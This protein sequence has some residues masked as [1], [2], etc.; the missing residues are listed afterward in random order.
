MDDN[1][2]QQAPEEFER[3]FF[4]TQQSGEL[5]T[6]DLDRIAESQAARILRPLVFA[7]LLGLSGLIAWQYVGHLRY[8]FAPAAVAPLGAAEDIGAAIRDEKFDPNLRSH[9]FVSLSGIPQRYASAGDK[10]VFK[11]IG[12]QIYVARDAA[13]LPGG[14]S[15][16]FGDTG[17]PDEN[18]EEFDGSG[19]LIAFS[20]L[21]RKYAGI[22]DFYAE[23]Y[24]VPFC[25]HDPSPQLEAYL[26]AERERTGKRD[27]VEG[28]LLIEGESPRDQWPYVAG[29]VAYAL[30]VAAALVR[31]IL[32]LRRRD[33]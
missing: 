3:T 28:Y 7:L 32:S 27:C 24:R 25:S 1:E 19:W 26:E 10:G 17:N 4:G 14:G 5:G 29:L 22:R 13:S 18:R 9:R 8:F 2:Q 33:A 30:I 20:D 15:E 16:T 23:N 6:A 21:P 11:L 12:A 31:G